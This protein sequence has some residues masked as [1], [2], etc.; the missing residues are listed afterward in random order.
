MTRLS[1]LLCGAD[2]RPEQWPESVW[3]ED[4]DL[5]RRA[6]ITCVTLGSAAWPSLQPAPGSFSLDWLDRA[7]ALLDEHGLA[8]ALATGTASPPAWLAREHPDA[9][10]LTGPRP[11]P[12][13]S[14]GDYRQHADELARQLAARYGRHPGL[15]FWQVDPARDRDARPCS[16]PR[17]GRQFRRWLERQYA[18]LENLADRWGR[19]AQDWEEIVPPSVAPALACPAQQLDYHRFTSESLLAGF[20]AEKEI[21]REAAPDVPVTTS[22]CMEGILQKSLDAWSWARQADFITL[23]ALA[24]PPANDP[25]EVAFACDLH[26]GLGG[27]KPWLLRQPASQ[28][29]GT[30]PDALRR[31]GQLRL[32]TFQAIACGAD[33]AAFAHWRAPATGPEKFHGAVI[34]HG[35]AVARSFG[36]VKQLGADIS[37]LAA[38]RGAATPAEVALVIDWESSWA[39]ELDSRPSRLDYAEIVR[40]C[41]RALREPDRAIDIVPAEADLSRYK[42]VVAPALHLVRPGVAESFEAFVRRGGTFVTTYFSG[43]VDAGDRVFTGGYPAPFRRLLGVHVEEFD[44]FPPGRVQHIRTALRAGRCSHW[45]DVITTEGAEVVATFTEDFHAHQPAITRNAVG[46]GL[47]Y[48]IGTQPEQAFLRAFLSELCTDSGVRPPLKASE[49]EAVTRVNDRGEFLFLLNHDSVVHSVDLGPRP[50]RDLLTGEIV[51]G[52]CLV[53]PCGVRVLAVEP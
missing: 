1:Q 34:P 31:P 22:L 44:P 25:T 29:A 7:I 41:Y 13:P 38:V 33:G 3:R 5:M 14:S 2:W 4:I 40:G 15:L 6:G 46:S 19:R 30:A 21:L 49:I 50:R 18:T 32:W 53:L 39:L 37:K 43:I 16:C 9:V 42:L 36:E 27:G 52:Q 45:A 47:A 20:L 24:G 26:R 11:Q 35:G 17:C 10:L 51:E 12:C 8:F 28:L 48:Y 23:D